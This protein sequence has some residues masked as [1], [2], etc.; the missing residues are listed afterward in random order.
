MNYDL[1]LL[2]EHVDRLERIIDVLAAA[3]PLSVTGDCPDCDGE[4]LIS[5][6]SDGDVVACGKCGHTAARVENSV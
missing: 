1:E 2:R 6:G 3:S 5:P 4:L